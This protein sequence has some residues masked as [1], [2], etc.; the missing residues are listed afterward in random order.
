MLSSAFIVD[1]S[2]CVDHYYLSLS[3][4]SHIYIPILFILLIGTGSRSTKNGAHQIGGHRSSTIS[5]A[6]SATLSFPEALPSA[7]SFPD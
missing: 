2:L 4:A 6:S 7:S 5:V 3:A 1:L